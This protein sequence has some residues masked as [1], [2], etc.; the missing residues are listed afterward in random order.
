[1]PR[2]NDWGKDEKPFCE[3]ESTSVRKDTPN[4]P[5]FHVFTLTE[6]GWRV[7]MHLRNKEDEANRKSWRNERRRERRAEIA[8]EQ[9]FRRTRKRN[10]RLR[11]L[12]TRIPA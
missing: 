6:R 11:C 12:Q 2:K 3:I 5:T 1:M 10:Q 8:L 4:G 7:W 9:L